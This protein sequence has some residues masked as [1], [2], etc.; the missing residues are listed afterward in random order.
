MQM[1][2]FVS[3]KSGRPLGFS[4][5]L[6]RLSHGRINSVRMAFITEPIRRPMQMK[7]HAPAPFKV[8]HSLACNILIDFY[9]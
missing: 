6:V 8:A 3:L 4:V 5:W 7:R 1:S 9:F 2:R